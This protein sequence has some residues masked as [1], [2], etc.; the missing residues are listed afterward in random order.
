M[1]R[2]KSVISLLKT[3]STKFSPIKTLIK[4]ENLSLTDLL[5]VKVKQKQDHCV[6]NLVFYAQSTIMVISG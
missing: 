1:G 5:A 2:S 4:I 3:I 6:S